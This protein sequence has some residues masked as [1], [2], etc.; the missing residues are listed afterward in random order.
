MKLHHIYLGTIMLGTSFVAAAV[1]VYQQ[2]GKE[3]VT[4]FSDKPSLGAKKVEIKPNVIEVEP[5]QP[6]KPADLPPPPDVSEGGKK[7]GDADQPE[8]GRRGT[9]GDDVDRS[10]IKKAHRRN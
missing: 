10:V 5:L 2:E 4:E 8:I 1:E 9:D 7:P 6:L 3:G